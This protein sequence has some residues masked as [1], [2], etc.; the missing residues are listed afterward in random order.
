MY[1]G[2]K[3]KKQSV[4]KEEHRLHCW[5]RIHVFFSAHTYYQIFTQHFWKK[6]RNKQKL[7]KNVALRT[8]ELTY[9]YLGVRHY[10]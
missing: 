2:R 4:T 3:G 10:I 9:N 8:K 7:T 5:L 1:F 6:L